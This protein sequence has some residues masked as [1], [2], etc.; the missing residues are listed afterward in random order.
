MKI[1]IAYYS[2][3]NS[4]RELA[5]AIKA[6]LERRGHSIDM[7]DVKPKQEHGFWYWFLIRIFKGE[8]DIEQ[9]K[10]ENFL[11]Y[12]AVCI[13][14]PNWTRLSLPMARYLNTALKVEFKNIYL[15]ST[16]A[17]W[18]WL[19]WYVFSAYFFNLTSRKIINK[20][21]G[22]F[23]LDI[24]LSSLFKKKWG[25]NSSYGKKKITELCDGVEKPIVSYKDYVLIQ[26]EL[27]KGRFLTISFISIF[28]IFGIALL[29]FWFV[30]GTG[31]HFFYQSLIFFLVIFLS[32]AII[33]Y[34]ITKNVAIALIKY[35]ATISVVAGWFLANF[36]LS[37]PSHQE[38]TVP[39]LFIIFFLSFLKDVRVIVFTG[40]VY[41]FGYIVFFASSPPQSF[42]LIDDLS[43]FFLIT[44]F[45][46]SILR[47]SHKNYLSLLG[48][49]DDLEDRTLKLNTTYKNL[50][51]VTRVLR[52]EKEELENLKNNL[53]KIVEE[54]TKELEGKV[55]ELERFHDLTVGREMKMIE[56]KKEI[57]KLK[58]K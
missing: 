5:L 47:S 58:G 1:L 11:G 50:L 49:Q 3:T 4:T 48:Y 9:P 45:V 27:E 44:F 54:R 33:V 12:D 28:T 37:P 53:G 26:R 17:L 34:L 6:E 56:L 19:E 18:P 55:E 14:S 51:A 39:F 29:F 35:I 43:I 16:T 31:G 15:F 20:K 46:A 32:S 13:G 41:F 22:R 10:I 2:R 40:L 7:E 42:S 57:E 21:R 38:I 23:A 8:C 30:F 52:E 24:M 36:L 25:V